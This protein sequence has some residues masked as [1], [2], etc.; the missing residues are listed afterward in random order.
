[1][2]LKYLLPLL[3]V[4]MLVV[5]IVHV[6]RNHAE[7]PPATPPLPPVVAPFEEALSA[8]GIVEASTSNVHVAAPLPG[9]IAQVFVH[10]GE[11]V[12]ANSPLFALDD[13]PFLAERLVRES[14]LTSAR[15]ELHRLEQL[16]REE[17][18]PVSA[19]RLG[20]ATALLNERT[21]QYERGRKLLAQNLIGV[22]ELDQRK[23][24]MV[25]AQEQLARAQAEDRLL[26]AGPSEADKA[27]AR[28]RVAEAEALV[29]QTQTDL[30]RL[31]VRAPVAGTVL[32]VNGR[33][34]EA[35]GTPPEP[36]IV[37]GE[38]RLLHLRVD[39]DEQQI[40]RFRESAPA[41]A[42][43]RGAPQP[44]FPLRFVRVE[45]LVVT[46]HALT[47]DVSERSDTRV[48]QVIYELDPEQERIYV[49][50]QMDVFI[51]TA[52]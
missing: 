46:K 19:A 14:R 26:R 13:R 48:L 38:T 34:G 31:T 33:A 35:V 41:R 20:E 44:I 3:S 43:R 47:G 50:Q 23:A 32:R 16:P 8:A 24:L 18:L 49:G 6:M 27:I 28:A 10:V 39:L 42:A 5:A 9:I 22:E 25:S 45:P 30:A 2:I 29:A 21:S 7:K 51:G 37:L 4:L 1:M 36:P 15:A 11:H 52:P 17:E 12:E 40:P